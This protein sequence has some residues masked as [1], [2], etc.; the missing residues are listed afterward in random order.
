MGNEGKMIVVV[1]EKYAEKT[2]KIMHTA[3]HG[4]NAA[5]IGKI[6]EGNGTYVITHLGASRVLDVLY[7]EGLP[8]I[9]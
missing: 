9:C 8:R 2:V 1:P 7:G 3:E 4:K 6:S 5:V